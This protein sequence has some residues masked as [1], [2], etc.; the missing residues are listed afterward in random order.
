MMKNV[1]YDKSFAF[2][3]RVVKLARYLQSEHKEFTLS[4]QVLKSGTSIGANIAEAKNAQSKADFASKIN[5][6][7][8]ETSETIYWLRLL[9]ATDYLNQKEASS[10]LSDCIELEKILV[11]ILKTL[12]L[13]AE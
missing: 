3:I 2:S 11:S 1:I 4:K 8:K 5:I 7:L 6:A 10:L 13:N 9:E 12:K